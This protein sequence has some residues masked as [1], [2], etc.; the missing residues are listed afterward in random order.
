MGFG[1]TG[2]DGLSSLQANGDFMGRSVVQ[3]SVRRAAPSCG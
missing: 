3:S 2:W 1:E